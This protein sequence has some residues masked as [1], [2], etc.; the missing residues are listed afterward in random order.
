MVKRILL[1]MFPLCF[2][3]CTENIF[4]PYNKTVPVILEIFIYKPDYEHYADRFIEEVYSGKM[5]LV[6]YENDT[7]YYKVTNTMNLLDIP[8]GFHNAYIHDFSGFSFDSLQLIALGGNDTISLKAYI[9]QL[10]DFKVEIINDS[11]TY[12]KYLNLLIKAPFHSENSRIEFYGCDDTLSTTM[13][14]LD[15]WNIGFYEDSTG[16]QV[17]ANIYEDKVYKYYNVSAAPEAGYDTITNLSKW[18]RIKSI[19]Q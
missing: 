13:Q 7:N 3:G 6:S 5:T 12:D 11:L 2:W 1:L 9:S 18:Y 10:P 19:T 8:F 15:Y 4:T 14:Y 17:I 16:R